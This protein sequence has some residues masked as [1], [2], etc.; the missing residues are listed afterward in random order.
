MPTNAVFMTRILTKEPSFTWRSCIPRPLALLCMFILWSSLLTAQPASPL[1]LDLGPLYD[2]SQPRRLGVFGFPSLKNCSHTIL[3]QEV[4]VS[5]FHGE[6]LR[7]SPVAATFP[8]YYCQLETITMTCDY[9]ICTEKNRYCDVKSVLFIYFLF[10][11]YLKLTFPSSQL[12]PIN[13]NYQE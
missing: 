10:S 6:V 2:C 9:D 12:K 4:I 8:I 7:Y 11:L 5:T 13:V 3:Q 1:A